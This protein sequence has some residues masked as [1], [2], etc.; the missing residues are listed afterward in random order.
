TLLDPRNVP[1]DRN[2]RPIRV[3]LS[4]YAGREIELVFA[5]TP[6]PGT[7]VFADWPG[8]ARLRFAPKDA[9]APAIP[10]KKIYEQEALV[11]EVPKVM[12]RAALYGAL[13]ILADDQVLDRLNQSA[14][15]ADRKV[16]VSRESLAPEQAGA[17]Q[18]LAAATGPSVRAASIVEYRSQ[19][20]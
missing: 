20:V 14:F 17:V 11:Y 8:W 2:G 18:S 15:D 6:G 9:A 1:A 16:V 4:R 19:H 10:F 12:P 13:E 7:D 5:T 3:D